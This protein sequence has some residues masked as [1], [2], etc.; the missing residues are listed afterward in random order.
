MSNFEK[1]DGAY[2]IIQFT[3]PLTEGVVGQHG[4]FV[5]TGDEY[6]GIPDGPIINREFF[7][8]DTDYRPSP[9]VADLLDSDEDWDEGT[10]DGLMVVDE[11]LR[12]DVSAYA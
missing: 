3:E 8:D 12:L 5:V 2:I 11:G 9:E 6:L 10:T 7:V 1:K 4:A